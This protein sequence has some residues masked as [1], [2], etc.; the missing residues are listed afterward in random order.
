MSKFKLIPLILTFVMS[1]IVCGWVGFSQ[2]TKPTV[3]LIAEPSVSQILPFEAEA[4]APQS[5]VKLTLQAVDKSGKAL[6]NAQ[7]HLTILTPPKNPW[8]TTDFPIVEGTKLLD[9]EANAPKGELQIQQMLPIRGTY[10]LLVNVTPIVKNAFAPIEQ[11]LTLSVP[12]NWLKYQNF[13]IL[14]TILLMV[15][16][17][18]G[19]IIGG[20]QKIQ[21]GEIAPQRV[22]LLLSAAIVVAIAALLYLNISAEIAQ[23]HMSMPA[24]H[25]SH[26]TAKP[27]N[28]G[29]VEAQGFKAQLSKDMSATVGKLANF[30]LQVIDTQ[31]NQPATDIKFNIKATQL[32]NQ[33]ITFASQNLSD[34]SGKLAWQQQFFDGAPHQIEIEIAPQP[35]AKRQFSTFLISQEIEVEGIAPPLLVRLIVL[36]Y[37]TSIILVG[38]MLGMWL[39]RRRVS[40]LAPTNS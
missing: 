8:F 29:I 18:G 26:H 35:N 31:T 30:E 34:V 7:I 11:T 38:L 2:E 24:S 9:I 33:W 17:A 6:E 5:P 23:S 16:L 10:Q 19:W 32:E 1:L 3:R 36:C 28:L 21:P 12:E 39:Q 40:R 37:F 13:I 20:E 4:T 22:R 14:A 15:G 25:L 27:N